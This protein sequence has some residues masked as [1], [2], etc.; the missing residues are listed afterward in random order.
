MASLVQFVAIENFLQ[1]RIEIN[2][3]FRG[4]LVL[5]TYFSDKEHIMTAFCY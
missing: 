1:G 3:Q 5:I 2:H 4:S